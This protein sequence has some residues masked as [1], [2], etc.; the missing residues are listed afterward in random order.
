MKTATNGTLAKELGRDIRIMVES[1]GR[2]DLKVYFDHGDAKVY[3]CAIPHF[4][5]YSN[6]TTLANIDVAAVWDGKII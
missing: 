6:R 2:R 1:S 3:P 4:S 5:E